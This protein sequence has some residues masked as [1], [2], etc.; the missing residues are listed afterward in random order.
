VATVPTDLGLESESAE[1]RTIF[2]DRLHQLK[3]SPS[4]VRTYI[5]LLREVWGPIDET[6]QSTLP[7]LEEAGR[8]VLLQIERDGMVTDTLVPECDVFQKMLPSINAHV[9][10]GHPL[11][12]APCYFFGKSLYL[13]FPGLTLIGSGF[14]QND[15]G[16]RAVTESLA[17]RLKTVADPTRLALLHYL[18]TSPSTVGQLATSFGLAQPTVSMHVKSLREAGLVKS[19]RREGRSLLLSE[20]DTVDA[21]V[22][23]LRLVAQGERSTGNVRMPA[24]VVEATRS[25]GPATT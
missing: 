17:R 19:E 23:E 16:A 22:D 15:L 9:T 21:L 8:R 24:T 3:S 18:A 20:P 2:L 6:W 7:V 4:L 5:A 1:D 25:A 14:Q 13:E 10:A 11:L 12:V